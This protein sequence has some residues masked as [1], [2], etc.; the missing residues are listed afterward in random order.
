M[1]HAKAFV[2]AFRKTKQLQQISLELLRDINIYK[3]SKDINETL[4]LILSG[5]NF[6]LYQSGLYQ[7]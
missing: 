2:Q 7:C 5:L 4:A 6:D 3:P 1:L